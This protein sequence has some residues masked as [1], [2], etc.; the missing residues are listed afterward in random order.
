MRKRDQRRALRRFFGDA[1]GGLIRIEEAPSED[2]LP[3]ASDGILRDEQAE[4]ADLVLR[5]LV[6][7][8][9]IDE[10]RA[11]DRVAHLPQPRDHQREQIMEFAIP[12]R[13]YVVSGLVQL[14]EDRL[15][16]EI[17]GLAPSQR[18]AAVDQ[19][20]GRLGAER[21]QPR[22]DPTM[23][24]QIRSMVNAHYFVSST[25]NAATRSSAS[26]GPSAAR[27]R[28]NAASCS[29]GSSRTRS[30]AATRLVWVAR[31]WRSSGTTGSSRM[32]LGSVT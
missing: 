4:K 20:P 13:R 8:P 1:R 26:G 25:A 9:K 30:S 19:E 5:L 7:Q 21:A 24:V 23:V 11:N 12:H 32:R 18:V 28:A 31:S 3:A 6:A 14:G 22:G 16:A 2:A 10:I 17:D 15:V 29:W 27:T